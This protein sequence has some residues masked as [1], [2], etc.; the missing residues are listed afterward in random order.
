VCVSVCEHS[1]GRISWSI[2]TKIGTDIWIPKSKNEFVRGQHCTTPYPIL[3]PKTTILCQEVLKIHANINNPISALNVHWSLKFSHLI[4]NQS[5]GTWWWRQMLDRKW[6]Y[7]PFRA[8]AM[9]NMQ[10]NCYHRNSSVIVDLAMG[11]I[12]HST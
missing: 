1:H 4:V 3:Q 7:G 9:K 12:R 11:Q 8:C 6:K 5:R 2:F 10:C